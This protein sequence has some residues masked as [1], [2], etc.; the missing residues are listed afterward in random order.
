[1]LFSDMVR[2]K[3]FDFLSTKV[4]NETFAEQCRA[5]AGTWLFVPNKVTM[6]A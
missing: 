2:M 1:M 6:A 5:I 4:K 3:D